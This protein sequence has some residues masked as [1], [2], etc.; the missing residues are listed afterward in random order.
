MRTYWQLGVVLTGTL[1]LGIGSPLKGLAQDT[2]CSNYWVNP[3]TGETECFNSGSILIP[4]PN[5]SSSDAPEN[6]PFVQALDHLSNCQP[7]QT[8][9]VM[10]FFE[11]IM[12]QMDIRSWSNEQCVVQ[13]NAFLIET[14]TIQSPV[15]V[16]RYSRQ[17]LALMTDDQ[18]Y[19]A[20]R[21]G[22]FTFDSS[23]P[24]DATLSEAMTRECQFS[25]TWLED[26][27]RSQ[28]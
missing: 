26:L 11:G 3:E 4:T 17:T 5:T 21:T 18:A 24:R 9:L 25:T 6:N 27:L 28:P 15:S 7:Y 14:P 20:A 8:Y 12:L 10:P 22:N 19:E 16:C 2:D 13:H 1:L 23:N